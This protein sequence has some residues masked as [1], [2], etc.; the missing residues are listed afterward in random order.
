MNRYLLLR[1][2]TLVVY[3]GALGPTLAHAQ[4][5]TDRDSAI[6]QSEIIQRQ[7]Q[8]QLQRDLD[9]ARR[10]S[11]A[12]SGAD[13]KQFMPKVEVPGIGSACS[14]IKTVMI[15]SAPH[16]STAVREQ[17]NSDFSGRCVGVSDI[18]QMLGAITKDYIQR[19]Y[20]TTRAYLPAQELSTGV[21]RIQVVEGRIERIVIDDDGAGSIQPSNAFPVRAGDLLNLRDLEQ[22]VD[23]VNRLS[24]NGAEL[25]IKPGD[26]VGAS[27]VVV[28]N[29]PTTPLHAT[30]TLDNQGSQSTGKNQEGLTL[31]A[32]R[33]LGLN[34]L[35]TLTH[36]QSVPNDRESR[37]AVSDNVSVV[38]PF[39]YSTFSA[40]VSRSTYAT[41]IKAPSGLLLR[42]NGNSGSDGVKLERVMYRDQRSKVT[43]SAGYT[44]K[45]IENYLADQFLSVSSRWL[46]VFD[47]AVGASTTMLGGVVST[48]LGVSNGLKLGGAQNDLPNLPDGAPH[49]QFSKLSYALS[50]YRPFKIGEADLSLSSQLTGQDS[51]TGL[52]GSEQI[53]IGGLYSVRGFSLNSISGDKGYYLRNELSS[54][55][56]L[57]L[58]GQAVAF[59]LYG[60]VDTG[61]VASIAQGALD[62]RLT[63]MALGATFSWKALAL[64]L[65]VAAPISLPSFFTRESPQTWVRFI[66]SI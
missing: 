16:L 38:V 24:S 44:S 11:G 40:F 60:A 63:G 12:P 1:L 34:E 56:T 9:A 58:G 18:E 10:A 22:G 39:G 29:R 2:K 19:G 17:M 48:S 41:Q 32:D 28:H 14:D 53:A 8:E 55:R 35:V 30:F 4:A 36:R 26:L 23:Q 20:I 33:M 52:Q 57:N 21:L 66:C 7:N 27:T 62:G 47:L 25:D 5:A 65:M 46:S 54:V 3:L 15:D 45:K 49:S 13:P 6:R 64:D 51:R 31:I 42:A 61:R 59:R 37:S 50:Y 43:L